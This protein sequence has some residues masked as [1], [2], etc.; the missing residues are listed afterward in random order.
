MLIFD[1]KLQVKS[2]EP[3]EALRLQ[4]ENKFVILDVR[5]EAEFK[6]VS[7]HVFEAFFFNFQLQ[8]VCLFMLHFFCTSLLINV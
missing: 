3:K 7:E 8:C 6:E 2:V 1:I 5:P 4:K